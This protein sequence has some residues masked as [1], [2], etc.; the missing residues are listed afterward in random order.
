M[1][2]PPLQA[3]WPTRLTNPRVVSYSCTFGII[4]TG[5]PDSHVVY[6]KNWCMTVVFNLTNIL[7]EDWFFRFIGLNCVRQLT[8]NIPNLTY[9]PQLGILSPPLGIIYQILN[10]GFLSQVRQSQK[11]NLKFHWI[12]YPKLKG[13]PIME[14]E[15][16]LTVQNPSVRQ[17][18]GIL[19]HIRYFFC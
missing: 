3:H 8:E 11:T 19:Y 7:W 18:L 13:G 16:N 15:R 17:P 1:F 5:E 2:L 14:E 6:S 9:Y 12:K 10:W 4:W